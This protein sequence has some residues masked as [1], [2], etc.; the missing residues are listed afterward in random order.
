MKIF[1]NKRCMMEKKY[2]LESLLLLCLL[3]LD[4]GELLGATGLPSVNRPAAEVVKPS[5]QGNAL[6]LENRIA[7]LERQVKEL[8]GGNPRGPMSQQNGGRGGP[9]PANGGW[10]NGPRGRNNNRRQP[11]NGNTGNRRP[12]PNGNTVSIVRSPHGGNVNR[13][14]ANGGNVNRGQANIPGRPGAG[15]SQNRPPSANRGNPAGARPVG[16]GA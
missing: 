14:Q 3:D 8:S 4:A 15:T 1:F 11:P 16:N 5:E 6:S 12:S 7:A 13:G 9:N 2:K 10:L